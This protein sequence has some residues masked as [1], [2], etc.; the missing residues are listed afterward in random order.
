MLGIKFRNKIFF[1][2]ITHDASLPILWFKIDKDK[3]LVE[4]RTVI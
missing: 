1:L 2:L 4:Y 3:G